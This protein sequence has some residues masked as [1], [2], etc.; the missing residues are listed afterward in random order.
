MF[1][2]NWKGKAGAIGVMLG[3]IAGMLSGAACLVA[4]LTGDASGSIET[5]IALMGGGFTAFSVGLS[6]YGTRE[7]IG[8][9]KKNAQ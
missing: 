8:P 2:G 4:H 1:P 6:Q 7:A 3:G 9:S 5:C